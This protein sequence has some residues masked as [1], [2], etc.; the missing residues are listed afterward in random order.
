[1]I[2]IFTFSFLFL[3]PIIF[4]GILIK[5]KGFTIVGK[6]IS[7]IEVVFLIIICASI[8]TML[9]KGEGL[10]LFVLFGPL[11]IFLLYIIFPVSLI[12]ILVSIKLI[13]ND[14]YKKQGVFLLVL[15]LILGGISIIQYYGD[16]TFFIKEI[17][18][19]NV[20]KN[21]FDEISEKLKL[22]FTQRHFLDKKNLDRPLSPSRF[23]VLLISIF[24]SAKSATL[25]MR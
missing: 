22:E 12:G 7:R 11:M 18:Q 14:L 1:M 20:A 9:F 24:C 3:I 16:V 2:N 13:K 25:R 23:F 19:S 21:K 5:K 15:S 6:T 10:Y 4:L 8:V 17:L